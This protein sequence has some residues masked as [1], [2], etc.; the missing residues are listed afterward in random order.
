MRLVDVYETPGAAEFL[1]QLLA[2][3]PSGANISHA[4]MPPFEQHMRFMESRP[5]RLWLLIVAD[6]G[7]CVGALC[8]TDRNEIGI[9]I[10]QAHQR[11]GHASAALRKFMAEYDP[12]PAIPSVRAGRWLANI[13][14][15]NEG[16]KDLF[17]GLGFAK[18][19]ETYAREQS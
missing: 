1:Y 9:F 2:E 16:S 19:Q 17:R 15:G 10:A 4:S 13:A 8:A 14:P 6:N 11:Q 7:D 18:I 3:R 12:L 5:Y